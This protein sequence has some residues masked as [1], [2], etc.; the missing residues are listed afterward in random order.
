M[1]LSQSISCLSDHSFPRDLDLNQ[2]S[3]WFLGQFYRVTCCREFVPLYRCG[4]A[5][6]LGRLL[7]PGLE[8]N[9][10][11]EMRV[12]AGL[13][14]PRCSATSATRAATASPCRRHWPP[15]TTAQLGGPGCRAQD[16]DAQQ[17]LATWPASTG[18]QRAWRLTAPSITTPADGGSVGHGPPR[19]PR[20]S[21]PGLKGS[22]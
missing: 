18:P 2:E 14:R 15:V 19:G 10:G 21:C 1:T 8:E 5:W 3:G 13:P 11:T 17:T 22:G 4:R 16:R 9:G 7:L 20:P 6:C 12:I